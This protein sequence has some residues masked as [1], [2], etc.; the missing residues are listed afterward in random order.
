MEDFPLSNGDIHRSFFGV[1][2]FKH[3]VAFDLIEELR[4]FVVVVI[5][6][7][8]GPTDDHD[9]EVGVFP[10]DLIA[11][12]RLEQVSMLVDPLFEVQGW[13]YRCHGVSGFIRKFKVKSQIRRS[14]LGKYR[15]KNSVA[16]YSVAYIGWESIDVK[17]LHG[18]E[19]E[20]ATVQ[21]SDDRQDWL[22]GFR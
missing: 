19:H 10:D 14:V 16:N 2:D 1:D 12:G 3:H 22:P 5:F 4:R 11:D 7:F 8:V 20:M 15:G 9:D 13:M 17:L 18:E 21:R 6:A